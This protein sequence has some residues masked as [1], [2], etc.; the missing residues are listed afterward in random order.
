MADMIGGSGRAK[1]VWTALAEGIDPFSSQAGSDYL[2][3]KT[4]ERLNKAVESSGLPWQVRLL[5]LS[6]QPSPCR[7]ELADIAVF[8]T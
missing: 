1:M 3:P 7:N 8:K 4:T 5:L 2:T 6:L